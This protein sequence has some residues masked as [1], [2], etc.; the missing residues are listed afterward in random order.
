[1]QITDFVH[2]LSMQKCCF[3]VIFNYFAHL[4]ICRPETASSVPRRLFCRIFRSPCILT[5]VHPFLRSVFYPLFHPEI[6]LSLPE[7]PFSNSFPFV[8][9][10]KRLVFPAIFGTFF[11]CF[12]LSFWKSLLFVPLCAAPAR[13]RASVSGACAD[14]PGGPVRS[15][16]RYPPVS[17]R[18]NFCFFP[19]FIDKRGALGVK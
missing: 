16:P 3:Y 10:G 4:C 19:L 2:G 15:L 5:Y 9:F 6:R 1:M 14:G 8:P 17:G 18:E 12:C 7:S 11:E 13:L